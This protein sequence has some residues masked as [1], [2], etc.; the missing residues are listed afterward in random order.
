MKDNVLEFEPS[1]SLFVEDDNPLVFYKKIAELAFKS[2]NVNGKLF[3][4][5]NE[6][7]GNE[8]M[9]ILSQTGFVHIELKKDV[10]DKERMIR[11]VKK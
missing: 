10:N 1:L 6:Q 3:F 8:I 5:T 11:A 4:E 2:L 9:S 7:F